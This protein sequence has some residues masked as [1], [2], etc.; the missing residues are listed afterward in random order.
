[1]TDTFHPHRSRE[2]FNTVVDR[3]VKIV[4]SLDQ[5]VDHI[6][7]RG[8]SGIVVGS[9][10]AYMTGK[11]LVVIR[12]PE[13][14][15]HC[16]SFISTGANTINVERTVWIDDFI[17]SGGTFQAVIE[18]LHGR[19][20]WVILYTD[21]TTFLGMGPSIVGLVRSPYSDYLFE[22]EPTADMAERFTW[23]RQPSS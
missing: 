5:R 12:K 22:N 1:M 10:V 6:A 15:P 8:A 21:G 13:E 11:K 9:V 14:Q 17:C 16:Y 19:P 3:C 20:R 23:P 4:Q 18:R 7:V 2:A